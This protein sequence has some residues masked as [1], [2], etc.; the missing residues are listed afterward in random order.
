M[1]PKNG[2]A[3]LEV[4]GGVSLRG[5][6]E[7]SGAKNAALPIMAATILTGGGTIVD[8]PCLLDVA[9]MAELLRCL[10]ADVKRRN[11]AV[12]VTFGKRLGY[13]APYEIVSRMRAS[14][15]VLGPLV[16]RC[17]RARVALPGGCAIGHRPVDL[18][19]KG[20]TALGAR[21]RVEGGY[22]VAEAARLRGAH[23]QL[24]GPAGPSVLATANTMMAATLAQGKTVIE[25][26]ACEPEIVD[27]ANFLIKAGAKIEGAG[28][29]TITIEGVSSLEPA[30]HRI[31]ADRIEAGTFLLAGAIT[32][33]CVTVKRCVPRHLTSLIAAL[34]ESGFIVEHNDTSVT[35][36]PP[37]KEPAPL[38]VVTSPYPGFPTDL[39]AQM[40]ALLATIRGVSTVTERVFPERFRHVAELCRLGARI[41]KEG[42]TA[43]IEGSELCGADV[44]ATDLRAGA[45][46]V[47]AGLAAS[48]VTYVHKLHHIDRG[49]EKL[50]VKLAKLGARIRR[51]VRESASHRRRSRS[52]SVAPPLHDTPAEPPPFR[53]MRRPA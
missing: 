14:V 15:C 32:R 17:G 39:Q 7:I 11:S 36:A 40:M 25:Q 26:A 30:E 34:R 8:A 20:L 27:L 1:E 46:L 22:I 48:G 29:Q 33:G 50:E 43:V 10:G 41:R 31:I 19:I 13:E 52:D 24:A 12:E 9:T 38:S 44:K 28:T 4:K 53:R 51:L 3:L 6:V 16:A 2:E 18:H 35:V 5:E 47:L 21:V 45:A 23:I 49:Y 42:A 37:R